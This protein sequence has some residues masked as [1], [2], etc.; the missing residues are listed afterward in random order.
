M[1]PD[2]FENR[3]RSVWND[4]KKRLIG[5]DI[6]AMSIAMIDTHTRRGEFTGGRLANKGYSEGYARHRR[7]S[8]WRTDV[9]DMTFNGDMLR[10]LHQSIQV[11]TDATV[12]I[13]TQPDQRDKTYYTNKQRRWLTLNPTEKAKVGDRIGKLLRELDK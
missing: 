3:L 2:E 1:T 9:V 12:T 10:S 8:G 7:K 11:G 13:E 5:N 4:N 6:G